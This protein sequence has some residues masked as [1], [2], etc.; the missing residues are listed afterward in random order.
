MGHNWFIALPIPAEPWFDQIPPP[1]SGIRQFHPL[2][3]HLTIAFLGPVPV[4]V[5]QHAFAQADAWPLG[6]LDLCLGTVQPLGN[7]RRPSAY[8]ARIAQGQEALGA[9]MEWIRPAICSAAQ[10]QPDTRPPLP[11][12]TLA[13][14]RHR[15]T[16]LERQLGLEWAQSLNLNRARVRVD[17]IALYTWSTERKHQLFNIILQRSLT[18]GAAS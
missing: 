11:H 4:A 15:A 8:A 12:I 3:L 10:I 5:A 9:A 18:L 16:D 6:V 17:R 13:R 2:D 14:P 1:P 7:S